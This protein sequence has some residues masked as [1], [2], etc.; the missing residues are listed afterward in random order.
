MPHRVSHHRM[1]SRASLHSRVRH[2]QGIDTGRSVPSMRFVR[3]SARGLLRPSGGLV[4]SVSPPTS[5]VVLTGLVLVGCVC[6]SLPRSLRDEVGQSPKPTWD[7]G[8]G[9]DSRAHSDRDKVPRD[10]SAPVVSH[11]VGSSNLVRARCCPTSMETAVSLGPGPDKDEVV[12]TASPLPLG[13]LASRVVC[14]TAGAIATFIG[15][16]RNHFEGKH[17]LR[18]EVRR[19]PGVSTGAF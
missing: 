8:I 3:R 11:G 1:P 15:T 19:C 5:I 6:V 18:L 16:T 13:H 4:G 7:N 2:L 12:V 17:V 14:P 9:P 10:A